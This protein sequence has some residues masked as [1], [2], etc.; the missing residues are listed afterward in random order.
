M[1]N[2]STLERNEWPARL[3]EATKKH[4]GQAVTIQVVDLTYGHNAEVDRT[5][6][7]LTDRAMRVAARDGT[8]PLVTFSTAH[9]SA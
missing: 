5:E 1:T 9:A 4:E 6:V 8:I 3:D 2:G 7:D